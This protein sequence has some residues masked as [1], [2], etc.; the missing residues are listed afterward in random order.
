[1]K[2]PYN[3]IIQPIMTE[4]A[5]EQIERENKLTFIVNKSANKH[6]IKWAINKLFS[7]DKKGIIKINT[8]INN[9]GKKKAIIKFDFNIVNAADIATKLGIF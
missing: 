1:M 7:V 9:K 5:F 3:I 2:T 6:Q 4:A 8:L